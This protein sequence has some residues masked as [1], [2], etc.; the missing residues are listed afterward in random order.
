MGQGWTQA[1]EE[2]LTLWWVESI[3]RFHRISGVGEPVAVH[4]AL[5]S[6]PCILVTTFGVTSTIGNTVKEQQGE[7]SLNTWPDTYCRVQIS[8]Q[9]SFL[10]PGDHQPSECLLSCYTATLHCLLHQGF[11]LPQSSR[12]KVPKVIISP[13]SSVHFS[14]WPSPS[15]CSLRL[16][17]KFSQIQSRGFPDSRSLKKKN[18]NTSI[19]VQS[20]SGRSSNVTRTACGTYGCEMLKFWK[21]RQDNV[22]RLLS[23]KFLKGSR[24]YSLII[25]WTK[26]NL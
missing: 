15:S 26:I 4:T 19:D 1:V 9:L 14:S 23:L 10:S 11:T 6:P 8:L 13:L 17:H 16:I 20:E 3:S 7:A 25:D 18:P 24:K 21:V 22:E 5:T 12:G 2:A